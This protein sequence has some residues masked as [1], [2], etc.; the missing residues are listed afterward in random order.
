MHD[1]RRHGGGRCPREGGVAGVEGVGAAAVT[2]V[3]K[4]RVYQRPS[5]T[6]AHVSIPARRAEFCRARGRCRDSVAGSQ[7]SLSE[8]R[9][10]RR[11]IGAGTLGTAQPNRNQRV[12]AV[13]QASQSAARGGRAILGRVLLA[14]RVSCVKG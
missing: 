5:L 10:W 7:R 14:V 1:R 6:V 11:G 8:K 4:M 2:G 12:L 9:Y 13:R 3:A